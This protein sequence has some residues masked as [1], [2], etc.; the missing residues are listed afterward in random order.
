MA[1]TPDDIAREILRTLVKRLKLRA[2]H[3]ALL[4]TL[5]QSLPPECIDA[6][7]FEAGLEAAIA[8]GWIVQRQRSHSIRLTQAGFA[9]V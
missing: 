2:G 9:A 3:G 4:E 7:Q 5:I 1:P 6:E 8:N